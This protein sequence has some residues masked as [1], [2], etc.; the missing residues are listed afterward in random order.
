MC[1]SHA[2]SAASEG[3]DCMPPLMTTRHA[4][5]PPGSRLH[6]ARLANGLKIAAVQAPD[7]RLQRLVGAVGIGYLDEPDEYRGLAHLL[8]HA[9]FLGSVNIPGAGELASWVGERGGRYNARTDEHTTDFH[10][11]LPP[12]ECEEGLIRL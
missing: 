12:E 1:M 2:S 10:L 5:L 11:H 4:G 3:V 8:E 9:L 7:A 6:E